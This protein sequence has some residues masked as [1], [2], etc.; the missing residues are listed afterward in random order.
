MALTKSLHTITATLKVAAYLAGQIP[1]QTH[2]YKRPDR[3]LDQ[4]ALALAGD[5]LHVL[6]YDV[7]G[8]ADSIEL[9]AANDATVARIVAGCA[10]LLTGAKV[11]GRSQSAVANAGALAMFAAGAQS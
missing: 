8:N 3:T 10:K 1:A 5:A 11:T 7:A 9:A 6:G 4:R 2:D